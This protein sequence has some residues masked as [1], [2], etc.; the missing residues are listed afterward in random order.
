MTSYA[1]YRIT[2]TIRVLLFVTASILAFDFFPVT[3]VMIVL[4]AL[5]NDGAIL[6]IAYD[7]AT[8]AP[9]PVTWKMRSVL[10]VAT[11]LG[12]RR[13]GRLVLALR[14][15]PARCSHLDD[16]T[17]PDAHVPE[18]V[19]GR[20]PDDL[21]DP[22][23]GPLLVEP[24]LEPAAGRGPG[25]PGARHR[26]SPCTACSSP[27]IGWGWAALVWA[28]ALAWFLVNDQIKVLVYWL[29][30][31]GQARTD[32]AR[33]TR[34]GRWPSGGSTGRSAGGRGVPADQVGDARRARGRARW[35]RWC[36]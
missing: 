7:R 13:P 27:R 12:D 15:G 11:A 6:T 29:E 18:A 10:T 23:P 22:D 19:G 36:R 32:A 28:Y 30:D 2:E 4:L 34:P 33:P 9:E 26:S 25:H 5:L 17:D 20:A 8:P 3:A 1:I 21:P 31:R 16:V 35:R 24:A 14:A